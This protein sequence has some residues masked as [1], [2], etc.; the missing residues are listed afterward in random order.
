LSGA[1]PPRIVDP[2]TDA[3]SRWRPHPA[4][5]SSASSTVLAESRDERAAA[6]PD[7]FAAGAFGLRAVRSEPDFVGAWLPW[8]VTTGLGIGMAL[9]MLSA[10]AVSEVEPERFG[11]AS[12]VSS[13]F[14]QI[15]AVVGTA[16][17]VAIVG[18]P[19][20]L[21][22]GMARADRAYL[23]ATLGALAAAAIALGLR[24]AR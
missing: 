6:V 2:C 23:F 20:T 24:P 18:D 13:A 19:Q 3:P 15:G 7:L 1:P 8:T 4:A 12:A 9:P 16:A 17:L 14:R 22:E 11:V 21:A 10:A 5:P